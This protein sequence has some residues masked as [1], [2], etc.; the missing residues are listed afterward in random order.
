MSLIVY[1]TT[2]A[3]NKLTDIF[4]F[5]ETEAGIDVAQRLVDGIIDKTISLDKNPNIGQKEVLLSNRPQ[6][7]R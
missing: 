3:E 6:C 4:N 2:F 5:Y 1:W 7:F